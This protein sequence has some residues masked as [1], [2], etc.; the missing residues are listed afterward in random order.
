MLGS[1]NMRYIWTSGGLTSQPNY[2]ENSIN[3]KGWAP[4]VYAQDFTHCIVLKPCGAKTLGYLFVHCGHYGEI[5]AIPVDCHYQ[6]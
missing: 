6:T 1:E 2:V 5:L 3:N 4:S